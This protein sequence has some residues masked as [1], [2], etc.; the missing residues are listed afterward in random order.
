MDLYPAIDLRGGRCVRLAQGDFGRETVYGTDPVQRARAFE[1]GGAAWLHVVDLDAARGAVGDNRA[2][3]AELARAVGLP[4]Q[5]GG[6]VRSLAD[7]EELFAAGVARVV[8][9]T[10]AVQDPGLVSEVSSR[11]P[12]RVAVGLDHFGGE[13]RLKGWEERS[14]RRLED[15]VAGL[16]GA[17]AAAIV[18]TDIS[19]DGLMVGPDLL[20]YRALL[21]AT[22]VP[23]IASGGVGHL[24]D[25]R[26]L[27]WLSAGGRKLAG[28]IVGRAIY[29]GRFGV[30]EA[31]AACRGLPG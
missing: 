16:A 2:V 11:W 4:V 9:G 8:M 26:K 3:V 20:G 30:A 18:V 27:A 1:A 10:A 24:D 13:V 23:V 14:G 25:V 28:V 12:G 31:V 22:E 5:V 15:V 7:A 19:R 21:E 6:G 17:V 29:E